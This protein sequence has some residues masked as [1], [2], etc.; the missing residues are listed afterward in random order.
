MPLKNLSRRGCPR[1]CGTVQYIM[2]VAEPGGSGKGMES[3]NYLNWPERQLL[4]FRR[5]LCV[6]VSFLFMMREDAAV[7]SDSAG[8]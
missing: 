2:L 7:E 8:A 6:V 5:L 4:M 1:G 3:R